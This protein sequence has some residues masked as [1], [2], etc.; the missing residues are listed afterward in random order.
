MY[1]HM[2]IHNVNFHYYQYVKLTMPI[3][4]A[5]I[6]ISKLKLKVFDIQID[7]GVCRKASFGEERSGSTSCQS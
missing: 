4:C 1:I 6:V 2:Y 7:T 3:S 5:W